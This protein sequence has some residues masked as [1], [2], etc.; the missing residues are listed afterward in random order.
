MV[1]FYGNKKNTQYRTR[2]GANRA[3]ANGQQ[4]VM[5]TAKKAL[6]L[7]IMTKKLLNVE[8]KYFDATQ[9]GV[10]PTASG[11]IT[12]F[13]TI[14]QGTTSITRNGDS[15]RAK[16]W[17]I[18]LLME[19]GSTQTSSEPVRV[20]LF[21]GKHEDTLVPTGSI[22][23]TTVGTPTVIISPRNTDNTKDFKILYDRI[24]DVGALADGSQVQKRKLFFKL[25]HKVQYTNGS[26]GLEHGGLYMAVFTQGGSST[27][28]PAVSFYS[29]FRFIDN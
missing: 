2:R 8:Y 13:N 4:R 15:I 9:T 12:T 10:A 24:I 7:A 18:N 16:S 14:G 21:Q 17:L 11:V 29:R 28:Y 19:P 27:A 23:L 22:L 5:D 3:Q 26:N 25:N 1:Q 6:N 20:I